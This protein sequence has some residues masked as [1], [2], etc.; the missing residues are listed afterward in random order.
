MHSGSFWP[1]ARCL[2][3]LKGHG[4]VSSLK[5]TGG[6]SYGR[7]P[8][9][10]IN[11]AVFFYLNTKL[12]APFCMKID[13]KLSASGGSPPSL[14]PGLCPWPLLGALHAFAMVPPLANSGSAP[15]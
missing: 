3:A 12:L 1:R 8:P 4:R 10:T 5:H 2:S 11:I 7:P 14:P 15:D 6:S 13:E 9:W